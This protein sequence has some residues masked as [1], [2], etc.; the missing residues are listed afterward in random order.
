MKSKQW[1]LLLMAAV[2]AVT[3]T[4]SDLKEAPERKDL[5]RL[6]V[7]ANSD[8]PQDQA[9]KL[10][11]RD[12]LLSSFGQA[13]QET[14]TLDEAREVINEN[15][16][17][18]EAAALTEIYRHGYHYPVKAQLG[19]FTFPTKAYGD[20]VYPAGR[21]EALRVVIGEGKGANWWCVMFPPL[22]FVDVSTGV[23]KGS[24]EDYSDNNLI[25]EKSKT[26]R[27]EDNKVVYTFK[28]KEWWNSIK[29]WVTGHA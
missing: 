4:Y 2:L 26:I 8:S 6:H 3:F 18:L 5:I 17:D 27:R 29:A 21:Y 7:I 22:C 24:S 1:M 13:F 16:D 20:I 23:A 19:T 12:Q 11:V 10:C 15:L 14:Y 9:L 28:L 25:K